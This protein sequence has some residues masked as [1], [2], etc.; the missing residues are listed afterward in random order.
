MILSTDPP[1]GRDVGGQEGAD[2]SRQAA[3]LGLHLVSG[4][5]GGFGTERRLDRLAVEPAVLWVSSRAKRPSLEF[6]ERGVLLNSACQA[7]ASLDPLV[8]GVIE[9][10]SVLERWWGRSVSN[11]RLKPEWHRVAWGLPVMAVILPICTGAGPPPFHPSSAE[12]STRAPEGALC[13]SAMLQFA[14]FPAEGNGVRRW[15]ALS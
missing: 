12:I 5:D 11:R 9:D 3:N 4:A 10:G 2:G 15:E 6:E 7:E 13:R 1:A 8:G 14:R